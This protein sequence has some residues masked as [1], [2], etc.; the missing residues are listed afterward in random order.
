MTAQYDPVSLLTG[1]LQHFSPSGSESAAA[2]YLV[3]QMR[4]LGFTAAVDEIGNAVG[5]IGS[6]PKEIVLLGHIDTVPGYITVQQLNGTLWGRGAVDAKGPLACFVSAAAQVEIPPEWRITVIG[7]VGEEED[8]RG[9]RHIR[10]HH[11]PEVLV[12]GEPSQWDRIT[13]GYKGDAYFW[14]II[15][16]P[17]THTAAQQQSACEAAVDFWNRATAACAAWNEDKKRTFDQLTPSLRGISS[18]SDGFTE[19]AQLTLSFRMP[20]GLTAEVLEQLLVEQAQDGVVE[21]IRSELAFKADKNTPLVRA[22][23]AAIRANEGK[24]A[25]A[26]KTGTSDMNTVAPAWKCPVVAYGP[27]DSQLDH[28]QNEHIQLKDYQKGIQVLVQVL[29]TLMAG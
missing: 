24:P 26:L 28:T 20:P 15:R 17:V 2:K 25:F 3:T 23:L 29:E 22:F 27:G 9:A 5:T 14:Y 1:L 19:S 16:R 4:Q 7:A 8:G 11:R 10:S 13:I 12:I 21:L 18:S 6:G